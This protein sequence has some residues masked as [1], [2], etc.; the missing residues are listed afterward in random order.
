[1]TT[2]V[3]RSR[4]SR[5]IRTFRLIA[6]A[7]IRAIAGITFDGSE[8]ARTGTTLSETYS[9]CVSIREMWYLWAGRNR[10]TLLPNIDW[11]RV[12]N[13]GEFDKWEIDG[14]S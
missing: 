14:I 4:Q 6:D 9:M 12:F 5:R 11:I 13:Q 7:A 10:G 2:R 1:M 3:D 8:N